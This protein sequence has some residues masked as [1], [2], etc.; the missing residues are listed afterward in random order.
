[1]N[2]TDGRVRVLVLAGND[3]QKTS[4]KRFR[5]EHFSPN[6]SAFIL[7]WEA[8]G[9]DPTRRAL[10]V[11]EKAIDGTDLVLVSPRLSSILRRHAITYARRRGVV[12]V[13]LRGAGTGGTGV[14]RAAGDEV[15]QWLRVGGAA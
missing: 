8:A 9:Y 4:V 15:D 2:T 7:E 10:D 1:M 12:V 14:L 11:V 5:G 13:Q 3:R 6:G